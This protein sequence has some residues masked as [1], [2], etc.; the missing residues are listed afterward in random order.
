VIE[1]YLQEYERELARQKREADLVAFRISELQESPIQGNFDAEHLKAIH[2]HIFQDFPEHRP[3][4]MREDTDSWVKHRALEGQRAIYDVPY[5]HQDIEGKVTSILED[6]GGPAALK[7][8]SPDQAA[9]RIAALYGDLDHAHGFYEGNSRT[10]REFTR[11]LAAEAGLTLDWVRSGVGLKE[12]NEL[13]MARDIEV[14]ERAY[15][16]LTPER[17]MM[18]N[19]RVEYESS[20]V[21]DGLRRAVGDKSLSSIVYE[22]LTFE[23]SLENTIA[24][25]VSE[26]SEPSKVIASGGLRVF[27]A[28]TGISESLL[29]F[30][31]SLLGAGSKEMPTD[32][33]ERISMGRRAHAA[34]ENIR[35]DIEAGRDLSASDLVHLTPTHL[36]NI[37]A[38]GD[39]YVLELISDIE[40]RQTRDRGY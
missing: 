6:F 18:T 16:E 14:L 22:G 12:R 3:G 33:V 24:F 2:A 37:K 10:L 34:I 7:D 26:K 8:L 30:V 23:Q 39:A 28:A 9:E 13:Y 31:D 27:D 19:D 29:S 36:E 17:A 32:A 11:E 25:S 4:V 35:D 1:N 21:L 15:P 20:F 5:A 40:R 38:K